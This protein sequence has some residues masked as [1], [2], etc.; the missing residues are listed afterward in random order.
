MSTGVSMD[1]APV[2]SALSDE[3]GDRNLGA[4]GQVA[5]QPSTVASTNSPA[6]VVTE[7]MMLAE[8][9]SGE[10]GVA[11]PCDGAT[12]EGIPMTVDAF[13]T[14]FDTVLAERREMVE[15]CCMHYN[16]C[17]FCF[18]LSLFLILN[19]IKRGS[20]TGGFLPNDH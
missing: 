14:A 5:E 12:V 3:V 10:S 11:I 17:F 16:C 18:V 20:A 2:G 19:A 8:G 9:P 1:I 4:S 6:V 15:V 13:E 7:K